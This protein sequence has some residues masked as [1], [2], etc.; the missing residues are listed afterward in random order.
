MSRLP[1]W[2]GGD[3]SAVPAPPRAAQRPITPPATASDAPLP[4]RRSL[5]SK[6]VAATLALLGYVLVAA[7]YLA[8]ER[9]QI[10]ASMQALERLAQHEK[11]V[12]LA[13]AR[14][15]SALADDA[16]KT[17]PARPAAAGPEALSQSMQSIAGLFDALD[18]FDPAY[19]LLERAI[20]RSFQA[21]RILPDR[22][23]RVDLHEALGRAADDLEIRR[24]GLAEQREAL[25]LGY[26]RQYDAVTVAS[27]LLAVVGL[28]LFGSIVAWFFAGLAG[29]IR[30]LEIHA[31]QIVHGARGVAIRVRRND[32]LGRLMHAVNR[33]ALDLDEREQQIEL[34]NQRR[35]HQD[36]MLSVAALAAGVAH[37]VN[38]PLAAISGAAQALRAAT[39]PP[40]PQQLD[41]ATQLI[42]A[43][44]ERAARAARQLADVAAPETTEPDWIDLN[45]MLR[46]VIQLSGYDRR[47]RHL[48][49]ETELDPLLPAVRTAG[50]ALRQVLM[51]LMSL[52]CEA[53]VAAGPQGAS[54]QVATAA[55]PGQI[56]LQISFPPLLDFSRP[57]VQRA[58]LICRAIIE[59]QGGH[60]ALGQGEGPLLRI[61]LTLPAEPGDD[62]G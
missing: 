9:G 46:R 27:A 18:D 30:R 55:G 4:L 51:Q 5:R 8:D 20:D 6:G 12:A 31:R 44:A 38:N 7:L 1:G 22:T 49:F 26:Q 45:A 35:S 60:L 23:N 56:T 36:K 24:N 2:Q 32:E 50:D 13:E 42:L 21:L 17:S 14:V 16:L 34:D 59:P 47:Y 33:M 37:E 62:T 19:A 3:A 28:A 10:L 48:R 58:L 53:M 25:A 11:A 40:T 43:Q 39:E 29:D 54:L 15:H 52:A 61:R 41:E 57:E